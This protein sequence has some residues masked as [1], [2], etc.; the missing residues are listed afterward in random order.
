MRSTSFEMYKYCDCVIW[1]KALSC[2]WL[3]FGYDAMIAV[4]YFR[5]YLILVMHGYHVWE[6]SWASP[7]IVWLD[8]LFELHS[9]KY[10][11]NYYKYNYIIII[12]SLFE[13]WI[14]WDLLCIYKIIWFC[15]TQFSIKSN[16]FLLCFISII[17]SMA[18]IFSCANVF[19]IGSECFQRALHII[20]MHN[21]VV[22]TVFSGCE[23]GIGFADVSDNNSIIFLI[24]LWYYILSCWYYWLLFWHDLT[25]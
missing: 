21:V 3:R 24:L 4:L 8:S 5:S 17:I 20:L 6:F 22:N 16:L 7:S 11:Y 9:C 19:S 13:Q 15:F 12:T 14:T 1:K 23:S 25:S 18:I 10:K 2:D